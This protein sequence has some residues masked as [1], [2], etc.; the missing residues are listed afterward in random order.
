VYVCARVLFVYES[1]MNMNL[2]RRASIESAAQTR[3]THHSNHYEYIHGLCWFVSINMHLSERAHRHLWHAAAD[4]FVT[5]A[6]R[7]E[8]L[9]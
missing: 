6:E 2:S 4:R 7:R 1:S 8:N 9:G 3:P 5:G